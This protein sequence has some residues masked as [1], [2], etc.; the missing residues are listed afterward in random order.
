MG[1]LAP[2]LLQ[3]WQ[4]HGP[5]DC[6]AVVYSPLASVCWRCHEVVAS[7]LATSSEHHHAEPVVHFA[8]VIRERHLR[9][10]SNA[11]I[12][13]GV[14]CLPLIMTFLRSA[15]QPLCYW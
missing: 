4:G 10:Q 1:V 2:L 9:L 6:L 12:L 14:L 5:L 15:L 7:V 11:N 8:C 3:I 13:L